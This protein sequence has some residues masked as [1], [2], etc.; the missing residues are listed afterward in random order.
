MDNKC[1]VLIVDDDDNIRKL[2]SR[3]LKRAGYKCF[4]AV[5]GKEG[6]D[7]LRKE[8]CEILITDISMPVMDG[9][10]LL[11]AIKEEKIDIVPLLFTVHG[12]ISNIVDAMNY[13]AFDF[14][15][16][17][18]EIDIILS[19]VDRAA[20]HYYLKTQASEMEKAAR[21]WE[22]TFD[23]SPD[24]MIVTDLEGKIIRCNKAAADIVGLEKEKLINN[25]CEIVLCRNN[26][27]LDICPF[28]E[29]IKKGVNTSAEYHIWDGI[30]EISSTFLKDS[31]RKEFGVMF[32]ARNVTERKTVEN[33]LKKSETRY[34]ALYDSSSIPVLLLDEKGV[35]D[36][37]SAT[38]K[39]FGYENVEQIRGLQLYELT[40]VRQPDGAE[41][42]KLAKNMISEAMN[43][44]VCRF[45]WVLKKT[46]DVEFPSEVLLN[47]I[48]IEGKDVLQAMITDIT[49][50]RELEAQLVHAQKME[51]IGQL[52]AGIAHEINTPTQYV[53]DTIYFIND[54]YNDIKRLID[55]FIE[56]KDAV[57][58]DKNPKD[59]ISE[60]DEISE[61]IEMD[62]LA[63]EIPLG[64]QRMQEGVE[65]IAKIVRAMKEFSHPGSEEKTA[66]DINKAIE[67]TITI[68]RNEWKYVS[69]VETDFDE[70]LPL[71]PCLPG[72]F[73][74][75]ILNLIVNASHAIEDVIDESKFEK[76]KI[77]IS[78]RRIGEEVEIRVADT[79]SG[80]PRK[81]QDRI[82]DPFFTT[83]KIGKG[84][85]QGL[86]IAHS[87]IVNK[88]RGKLTFETTEGKGTTFIIA[89]PIDYSDF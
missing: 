38:L 66:I 48:I 15:Q 74:Q 45:E 52:A 31:M 34:R 28:R 26:D 20:L 88:H 83:K 36:C 37:N 32:I 54:A 7:S 8:K 11:A 72:D 41:S 56:L 58:E 69:D 84:T 47:A 87:V 89:L 86:A 73:N 14:I 60:I 64:I 35:F 43:K 24:V 57:K 9:L 23:F 75:V 49:Y 3:E 78:T 63:E 30:F 62:Y 19:A 79:G 55:K 70:N 5:N 21:E 33:Q 12:E 51:S 27:D 13:G 16:K 39:M 10:G 42:S 77:T 6:L 65:R 1:S 81:V 82:F 85:G 53:G 61:E 67:S 50:R 68:A 29:C 76:G 44:G 2:L 4:T 17:P 25:G 71:V 59:M 18:S 80:I 22:T 46:D 40:P